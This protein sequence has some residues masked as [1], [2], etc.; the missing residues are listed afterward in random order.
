MLQDETQTVET[1]AVKAALKELDGD[2]DE[3]RIVDISLVKDLKGEHQLT[4]QAVLN[5]DTEQVQ[6]YIEENIESVIDKRKATTGGV[7]VGELYVDRDGNLV[8]FEVKD[9]FKKRSER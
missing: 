3:I 7:S 6:E 4:L 1:E 8:G 2:K 9:K 5:L